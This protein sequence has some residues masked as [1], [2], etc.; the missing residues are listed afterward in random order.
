MLGVAL[1]VLPICVYAQGIDIGQRE[2]VN[3]CAVCHGDSGRGDGP[4]AA[5][6]KTAPADITALQKNN[7]GVFP[8]GRVY[9]VIDGRR[10]I[11]GHGSS[12]M[13]VWGDR[14]KKYNAELAELALKFNTPI[15]SEAFVR[16]RI[17]ALIRYISI[18][19]AK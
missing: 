4:I 11:V 3:S 5:D 18:L 12:D 7:M 6:L 1:F 2:Y 16:G 19:Q 8:F 15:D 17:L 14:F 13:P 9:E 10:M